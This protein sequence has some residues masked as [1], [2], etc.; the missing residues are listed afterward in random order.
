MIMNPLVVLRTPALMTLLVC[1]TVLTARAGVDFPGPNP[2]PA[3]AVVKDGKATL[4]NDAVSMAWNFNKYELA[5][6]ILTNKLTSEEFPQAEGRLFRLETRGPVKLPDTTEHRVGI[7]LG[8]ET[9]HVYATKGNGIPLPLAT[10][11]RAKFPGSPT[12]LRI[13]KLNLKAEPIDHGDPGTAGACMVSNLTVTAGGAAVPA[14]TLA[15]GWTIR[16]SA[17]AGTKVEISDNRFHIVASAH[18]AAAAERTVPSGA[19][20]FFCCIDKAT[21]RGLSWGPAL[22]LAWQDGSFILI[23]L[24]EGKAAVFNVTTPEGEQILAGRANPYPAFDLAAGKDFKLSTAVRANPIEPESQGIRVA[25]RLGG[26]AL[27][28]RLC[29]PQTGLRILWRAELR[30]GSNYFRQTFTIQATEKTVPLY[31]VE[32]I[33]ERVPGVATVGLCPGSPAAGGGCFFGIEM[34]GARNLVLPTGVRMGVECKLDVSKQQPYAFSTV[35]GVYPQG[36]LRRGFLFYLERER[37]R[38]SKPFLHYNAWYDLGYGVDEKG[39]LDVV[40][41]FNEELAAKRGVSVLSYL[42]D[43][44]WDDPGKGLWIENE[45]KFPKGFQGTKEKMDKVGTHLGIWISPLGGYGGDHERLAHARRMGLI[46]ETGAFDLSYPAYKQWFQDRCIQLMR[47]AGVNVFKWDRAGEGVSPHFMALLDIA[48]N[49]RRVNPD[50]FINVTVG[51]WPSPFWLNYVDTTWRNGSGDVGWAGKGKDP[52]NEKY[53]REKWLT[54]RDGY[55]H[56]LFVMQAPLYPL[57]SVMHHGIVHGRAFQGGA[58][59]KS[60]SADLKNEARSYFAN[61]AM[62]QELYLTPSLMTPD[63]WDRV[64]EAAKW[65]HGHAE[66]LVDSHWVGGD[67]LKLEPYGYAAWSRQGAVLVLRNPSDQWQGIALDA[68]TTFELPANAPQT[69]RLKA[70]YA[71]QRVKDLTLQAGKPKNI[72]LCPFEVLVFD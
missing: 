29:H 17:R 58:I 20:D 23:G 45:R 41:Q 51:T 52:K 47:E 33:D 55:C 24:R 11:P 16:K 70:A 9:V 18:S 50:V 27:E 32:L 8:A 56:R 15:E 25:D 61:G 66:I 1:A 59:G 67:P 57:N 35:I 72:E 64:A 42:A 40:S 44:G 54:F 26:Q 12:W 22:A 48:H 60:N 68:A 19:T 5:P 36:Q 4:E 46:P 28:A 39:L 31:G 34:P 6:G 62:L 7:S 38:P 63:A 3:R 10:F 30:D 13:G 43:D 21:D 37:A 71:D 69:Y 49:L 65:A 2:G 14:R 53:D